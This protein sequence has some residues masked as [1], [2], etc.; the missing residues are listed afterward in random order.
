MVSEV[1]LE[2][3]E[4]LRNYTFCES[5]W[6]WVILGPRCLDRVVNGQ[7]GREVFSLSIS[8]VS[9]C[10]GVGC[11]MPVWIIGEFMFGAMV[12]QNT[13]QVLD[14]VG[15]ILSLHP[16]SISSTFLIPGR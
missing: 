11:V 10:H 14:C 5:I 2:S 9:R 15:Q 6:C 12:D 3:E 8:F 7:R 1:F 4:K 16:T 13:S